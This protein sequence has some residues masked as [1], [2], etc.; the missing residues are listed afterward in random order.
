MVRIGVTNWLTPKLKLLKDQG[1][2]PNVIINQETSV[3]LIDAYALEDETTQQLNQS[4]DRQF[5][6][7]LTL[8]K[9]QVLNAKKSVVNQ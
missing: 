1:V 5:N 9:L 7:A 3:R 4:E 8:L 6:S 2:T